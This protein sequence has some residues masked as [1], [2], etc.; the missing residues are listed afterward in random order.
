MRVVPA[1][2]EGKQGYGEAKRELEEMVPPFTPTRRLIGTEKKLVSGSPL[3]D[4]P[5]KL[6]GF[7]LKYR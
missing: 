4:Q 7:R 5:A 1:A 2:E 6:F 3:T